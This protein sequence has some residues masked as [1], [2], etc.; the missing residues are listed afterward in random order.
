MTDHDPRC[1]CSRRDAPV[2]YELEDEP[3]L[4]WQQLADTIADAVVRADA[5]EAAADVARS[6]T[7]STTTGAEMTADPTPTPSENLDTDWVR[8]LADDP[9]RITMTATAPPPRRFVGAHRRR[10]MSWRRPQ[11]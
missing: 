2:E 6:G 7:E 11:L 8:A 9:P 1:P 10:S 5:A 3:S 4:R